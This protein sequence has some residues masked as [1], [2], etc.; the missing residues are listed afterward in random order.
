MIIAGLVGLAP[1]FEGDDQLYAYAIGVVAGTLVQLLMMLPALRR[2]GFPVSSIPLPKRGDVR[3]RRVLMLMLPVSVGLGLI[4]INLLLNSTI[5][6]IVSDAGA[7]RDRRRLPHLH[8]PA[9][10]VQRRG[11]DGAVPAARAGWPRAGT[12]RGCRPRSASGMRQIA[13]LLIPAGAAMLV[14]SEPMVR[15]V[16]ERGEF[17]AESTQL[18]AEALFWF[19]FSLPFSGFVLML[20]RGFFSLQRPWIPTDAGGRLAR[21]QRDRLL[22]CWPSRWGSAAS[23]S[24]RRSPTPRSCSPRRCMLRRALGGF[25]TARTLTAIAQMLLGAAVA[26]RRRLRRLVGDR[27]RSSGAR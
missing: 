18:T 13:L 10:H 27:R 8:A 5:G 24:A 21:D 25:Q 16:F 2:I 1:L 19:T 20:T 22:R 4:N 9:G 17:D 26:R 12:T 6:S 15:L 11:G 14:L 7:A 23:C 3:V